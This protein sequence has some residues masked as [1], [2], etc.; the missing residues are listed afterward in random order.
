MRLQRLISSGEKYNDL[1]F[2]GKYVLSVG[3]TLS[4]DTYYN[5]F[6]YTKYRQYTSVQNISFSCSF[7]GKAK[8][9]LCVYTGEESVVCEGQYE[10]SAVLSI[11]LSELPD[12]GFLYPKITALTQC[13]FISG[14][15]LSECEHDDISVCVA[16][17]TYKREKYVHHNIE[18]IKNY[19]FRFIKKAFVIDNGKTLDTSAS[20]DFV[21]VLENK[22]YGGSGGFTRGLIE[23]Y[24]GGYS[25]VILMDDDIEIIP[26]VLETMTAFMS[27]LKKEF[28]SAHFATAMLSTNLP[29]IQY[30]LGGAVWNG[31]RICCA[32][33]NI[34]I[35]Y[36]DML[37]SNLSKN[38]IGYGSWWCYM[39]PV[40][41]IDKFGLPFPFFIKRDD[42]EYGMRTCKNAPII[43]MNGVAVRHDDFDNKYSMYLEYYNVRNQLVL[44]A[45]HNLSPTRNALY[46]LFAAS[47]KHLVLY[48]YDMMPLILKAFND[49]LGGVD[50]FLNCDEEELNS[51]LI[52]NSPK[53]LPLSDILEWDENMRSLP[54][55]Q[56]NKVM[57]LLALLTFAG[58]IIPSFLLKKEMG[59]A[60]LS[61]AGAHDTLFKKAV[62]QYQYKGE[63]GIVTKRSFV[64]FLKYSIKVLAMSLKI[65]IL[66]P[67]A[68]KSIFI[69]K[70][71]ITSM[72]FWRRH[73]DI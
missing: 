2:R 19:S 6:C 67:K 69:R 66:N 73:L 55:V 46:R 5:C 52:K 49:Y 17:C 11:D 72:E 15:Y 44:N 34:D 35:R 23:A 7:I 65:I 45:A 62:I 32:K 48:R 29:Y 53:L 43:T 3:D 42:V 64:K 56:N 30:E 13:E 8:V 70:S 61:M 54:R 39:M 31:K 12:N 37:L 60:P 27:V 28:S 51:E 68:K 38:D 50:F 33:R 40:S 10:N 25:H 14:E 59:A 21:K 58:H 24:N 1:L 9:Q 47:F 4:F 36:Q 71:E 57:T 26:E 20:D 22:N 18:L 41:D 16:I 63:T